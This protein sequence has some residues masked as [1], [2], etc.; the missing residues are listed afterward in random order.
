MK[1][2]YEVTFEERWAGCDW[3]KND[4]NVLANGDMQHAIAK[5]KKFVL[6]QKFEAEGKLQRC[7][8]FR[9]VGVK[10]VLKIDV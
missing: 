2:V 10:R 6:A 3:V 4:L 7:V 5:A 1:N 9:A 8:A